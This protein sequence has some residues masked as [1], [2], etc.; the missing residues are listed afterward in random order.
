MDNNHGVHFVTIVAQNYLAYAYV[1]GESVREHHPGSS[2]HIFV[3]DDID[4]RV[5]REIAER[6]FG[7]VR[8]TDVDIQDYREFV[9]KYTLTEACTGVKPFVLKFLLNN[10]AAKAIYLDPDM[11]CYREMT[12]VIEALDSASIVLTPHSTSPVPPNLCVDDFLFLETGTFNLGFIAIRGGAIARDFLSWWCDRLR[13][14]CLNLREMNLF[15][16]QKW[17]DLV[18]AYFE[19]VFILKN[20]SYNIAYWNLHERSLCEREGRLFVEQSGEPVTLIHFSGIDV[21]DLSRIAKYVARNP[22]DLFGRLDNLQYSLVN[23]PDLARVFRE[24]SEAVIAH[25]SADYS[26]RL[27]AYD[28]YSNG[29]KIS[30]LER[31]LFIRR[32]VKDGD[33]FSVG[34]GS[35]WAIC[36]RNGVRALHGRD[37]VEVDSLGFIYRFLQWILETGSRIC[38]R[39]LSPAH[40]EKLCKYVSH[41]CLLINQG[42]LLKR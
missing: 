37:A 42:S 24:Y 6:G 36:R 5:S 33:P 11:R 2:F 17:V 15:V 25:G 21:N 27:Y 3:M 29:D 41:W 34:T 8:P 35:Y 13:D 39:I 4:G 30:E 22:F 28:Y 10:G 7:L 19:D 1:L 9:F 32:R 40:Y 14:W 12:E 31:R 26:Q 23:R 16:D 38:L 18:P 20:L